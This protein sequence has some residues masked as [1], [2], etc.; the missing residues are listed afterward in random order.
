ME[1][2]EQQQQNL[3]FKIQLMGLNGKTKMK[4]RSESL[5]GL[6]EVTLFE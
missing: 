2:L 5:N 6:I 1:I 4:S 3:K